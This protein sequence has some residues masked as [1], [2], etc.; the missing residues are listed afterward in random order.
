MGCLYVLL[1]FGGEKWKSNVLMSAFLCPGYVAN[2]SVLLNV[3]FH[4]LFSA[5]ISAAIRELR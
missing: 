1:V 4:L 5:D 3:L 2:S